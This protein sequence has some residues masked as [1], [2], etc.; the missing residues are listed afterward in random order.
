MDFLTYNIASININTI[1]N[2]TKLNA[3][4]NFVRT[5]NLDIVFLQEVEN[6][7]LAIPGFNLVCNVDQERRGTAIAL[8]Q[9][10]RF[11]H[12]ERSLD[13]RLICLRVNETTTLCN[14]YAPSGTQHRAYR[15][16]FFNGTLAHYLRQ[17]TE[18]VI[19]GGDFNSV[20]HTKDA[21]GDNNY[22]LALKNATQ[23]L[24]LLDAWDTLKPNR[25]EFTYVTYNSASRIDRFYVSSNLRHQLRDADVHVC[26]FTNHKALTTRICLP[27]LGREPGRGFWSIRPHILS[28]DN[29]EEFQEKWTYWTRHRRNFTSWIQ[30]WVSYVKPRIRSFFRWKSREK[31]MEFHQQ[32]QELYAQLRRAYD[33]YY[34]DRTVLSLIN[35]I[36]N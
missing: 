18:Y 27:N 7:Q 25:V 19:L 8:K 28:A 35:R 15:E 24:Q 29:I 33:A 17:A 22:S 36:R 5:L 23:Q 16:N 31:Y 20:I 26:S 34:Q 1:S 21:T 10:I 11:S 3:L 6:D 32:H 13:G 30:W 14:I 4:N 9:H 12:V 2:H